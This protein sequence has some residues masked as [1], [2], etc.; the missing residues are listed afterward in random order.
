MQTPGLGKKVF[1]TT[2]LSLFQWFICILAGL[3]SLLC[4]QLVLFIPICGKAEE[5]AAKEERQRNKSDQL[6]WVGQPLLNL[7]SSGRR[8]GESSTVALSYS[9]KEGRVEEVKKSSV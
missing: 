7:R 5:T 2:P 8:T 1:F 6:A 9:V 4:Y 3:G